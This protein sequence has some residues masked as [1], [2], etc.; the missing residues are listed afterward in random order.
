MRAAL[1]Q[2]HADCSGR[3]FLVW[4]EIHVN[5]RVYRR[6]GTPLHNEL[7]T[8]STSEELLTTPVSFPQTS[9]LLHRDDALTG[10]NMCP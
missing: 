4:T 7:S 8:K 6:L 9:L 2:R 3:M 1:R 10:F 5:R